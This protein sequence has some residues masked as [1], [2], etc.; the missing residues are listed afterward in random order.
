MVATR[1]EQVPAAGRV[2]NALASVA[3]D[4]IRLSVA[5]AN[6][7][8]A[9]LGPSRSAQALGARRPS[10]HFSNNYEYANK[11]DGLIDKINKY[12]LPVIQENT[13]DNYQNRAL[14][15]P[16]QE[17]QNAVSNYDIQYQRRLANQPAQR[18]MS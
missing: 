10:H 5:E 12:D 7:N 15:D 6:A 17:Y 2:A 14:V 16:A 9:Q 11:L 1:L 13:Y 3:D 4:P 8:G 18:A